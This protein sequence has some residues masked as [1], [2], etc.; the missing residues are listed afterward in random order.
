MRVTSANAFGAIIKDER[1]KAGF[2]QTELGKKADINQVTLSLIESGNPATRLLTI[3]RLMSVLDLEM[4]ISK[5]TETEVTGDN[6]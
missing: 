2:T 5:R 6:W 4:T 3:L 1:K